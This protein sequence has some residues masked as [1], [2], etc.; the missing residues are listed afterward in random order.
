MSSPISAAPMSRL[1][2]RARHL[3]P[4]Y[5]AALA[6]DLAKPLAVLNLG[7]VGNVDL[8]RSREAMDREI[9]AFDTGP[10]NALHRRLGA[11]PYRAAAD[12][13]GALA[14]AG[15]ASTAHVG[16]VSEAIL[17]RRV[18]AEIARPRRFRECGPGRLALA[19]GAATLTEMTAAA[20]AAAPR[21]SRRRCA[22]GWSAAAAAQPGADGRAGPPLWVPRCGRSRRSAGMAMRSK[23]RPSPISRCAAAAGLPL[24]LPSTTGVPRPMTGGRLLAPGPALATGPG[25][26]PASL[27]W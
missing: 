15:Q 13:D 1:A 22:S 11:A 12:I 23:R 9:L 10:G 3:A 2:G 26:V 5:H 4:L 18:A 20:V 24:S 21:I 6:A 25:P 14:H 17:F 16:P 7:G 19:D 27:L 8:D